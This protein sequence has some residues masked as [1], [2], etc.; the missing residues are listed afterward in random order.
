MFQLHL[1]PVV[2]ALLFCR[3]YFSIH[4]Q[5]NNNHD[6]DNQAKDVK[7]QIVQ[8]LDLPTALSSR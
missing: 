5:M 8:K 1:F 2:S 3:V 4:I 6:Y 7:V